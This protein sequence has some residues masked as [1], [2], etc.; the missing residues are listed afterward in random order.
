MPALGREL[1]E[2]EFGH[3]DPDV[4]RLNHGE[5]CASLLLHSRR[6]TRH[7]AGSYGGAPCSVLEAQ[8]AFRDRQNANPDD[9][10]G[11][12]LPKVGTSLS[13]CGRAARP[14]LQTRSFW[15][16]MIS[17]VRAVGVGLLCVAQL[18]EEARGAV[19]SLMGGSAENYCLL[20]NATTAASTV[21]L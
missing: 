1:R 6:L 19:A 12:V 4:V 13:P 14:E 9:F 7:A 8:A 17:P 21:A 15:Q 3:L 11:P 10:L 2:T 5:R 20:D 16:V 18:M